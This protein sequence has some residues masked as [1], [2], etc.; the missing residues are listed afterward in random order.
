MRKEVMK[1]WVKALRSGKFKQGQG[2]LKQYNSKGVVQHC[3]LGV[4][5]ELYNENMKKN[6]KKTLPE[7]I[8]DTCCSRSTK[9]GTKTDILPTQVKNWAG[10]KSTEGDWTT[11]NGLKDSLIDW[12]DSGKTFKSIANAID[13]NWE[14][15]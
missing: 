10:M 3:C 8:C 5:C 1:K 14:K 12:N 15:L 9:F 2:T 4:L 13:N 7:K 6:H 11:E